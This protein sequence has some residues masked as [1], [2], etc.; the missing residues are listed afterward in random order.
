M[1]LRL[2][3]TVEL[4]RRGLRSNGAWLTSVLNNLRMIRAILCRWW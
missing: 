3:L 4:L 2:V 1:N